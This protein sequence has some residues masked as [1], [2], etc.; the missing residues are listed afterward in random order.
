M[1]HEPLRIREAAKKGYDLYLG[2]HTRGGQFFPV[3]WITDRMYLL[4]YGSAV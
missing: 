4:N 2:G 3:T 1:D